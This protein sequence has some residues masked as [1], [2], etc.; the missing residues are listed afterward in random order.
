MYFASLDRYFRRPRVDSPYLA[1]RDYG[2]LLTGAIV[3]YASEHDRAADALGTRVEI[4]P[5]GVVV[6]SERPTRTRPPDAP[7]VV[8]TLARIAPDKKL[9]QLILAV[10]SARKSGAWPADATLHVAGSAERGFEGYAADLRARAADLPIVWRGEQDAEEFLRTLDAFAMVSEPSGCPNASLEA[11][12]AGL[13]VVATDVGGAS[14]QIVHDATGLLV[15][16]GDSEAIGRAIALLAE[17]PDRRDAMGARGH[18]RARERFSV[19]RMVAD[20][21]RLCLGE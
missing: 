6:P 11:M 17:D 20:Y 2:R 19:D 15:P 10:A 14:E 8:G 1:P 13:A 3:K 7:F 16:R 4:V 9:E 18:E 5:N 12:A 21:A